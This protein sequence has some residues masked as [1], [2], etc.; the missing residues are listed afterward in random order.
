MDVRVESAGQ[1][2]R[3]AC[4]IDRRDRRKKSESREEA[5][6]LEEIIGDAGS[7]LSDQRGN[8]IRICLDTPG[9]DVFVRVLL[10]TIFGSSKQSK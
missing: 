7:W 5:E 6:R 8:R 9:K 4:I 1:W 3:G 10:E 2:C